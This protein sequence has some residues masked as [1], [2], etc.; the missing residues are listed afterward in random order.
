MESLVEHV[1]GESV[2]I[3]LGK[4]VLASDARNMWDQ[5]CA[6]AKLYS[7]PD[8]QYWRAWNLY[9]NIVGSAPLKSWEFFDGHVEVTKNTHNKIRSL[10]I[11]YK[12]ARQAA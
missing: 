5:V 11:A 8:K 6:Y 4:K 2:E 10:N 7:A 1:A 12:R 3:V 9:K